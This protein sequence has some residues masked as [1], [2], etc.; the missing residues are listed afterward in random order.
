MK[1]D[2]LINCE[3]YFGMPVDLIPWSYVWR[4]DRTVQEHPEADLIVRRLRR[5]DTIYR[6]ALPEMG[7]ELTKSIHYKQDAMLTPLLPVPRDPLLTGALWVGGITDYCVTLVWQ[8]GADIPD[9][10]DVEVRT[11]PCAWGWFGFTVDRVLE[12]PVIS[13]DGRRWTYTPPSDWMM[14]FAYSRQV[15]AASE[16]IAVFAPEG[17]AIPTLQITGDSLGV[18]EPLDLCVEW[19]HGYTAEQVEAR[20]RTHVAHVITYE[21]DMAAC[22]AHIRCLYSKTGRFGNDSK[23][24]FILNEAEGEGATVLL[25]ELAEQ[26][27]W[28]KEQ[29]LLF[30]ADTPGFDADAY[31]KRAQVQASENIRAR[32]RAHREPESFE[33]TF[34]NVR[35]WR[36][37]KGSKLSEFPAAP[38]GQFELHVPDKQWQAMYEHA[39]EQLRG[40]HMWGMLSS[41]VARVTLAMELNGLH[42]YTQKIYDYFLPSPGIK[43]DGDFTDPSGSL[44]WARAMR[45][46]MGY[47]HEGTH[48]STGKLLF[49]MAYRYFMT[50]DA[51]WMRALLPRLKQAADFIIRE[52]NGYLSDIPNRDQLHVAGLMPPIMLGDYALPACDWRWYYTDNAYALLGLEAMAKAMEQLGDADAAHYR[53][54]AEAFRQDLLRVLKREVLSAPVRC[55]ADGV[56]RSFIP[57]IAYGG[58]LLHY[59]EETNI[60]QYNF[61]IN[62]LFD[63]ALA[64]C[65][66][67]G[68]LP[69]T[70]RRAIGTVDGMEV[71]GMKISVASLAA[72]DHPAA[73][74][75]ARR[76]NERLANRG[77]ARATPVDGAADEGHDLW[78]WNTFADLPKISHNANLYLLQDDIPGFLRFFFNHAA[79]MVG[80]N[81]KL[82][83]H[84]HPSVIES[85]E[86]PDNGTAGWFVENFRNML[87]TEEG[88]TLWITKGTPRAWL[89]DGCEIRIGGAPTVF[90]SLD[91]TVSSAVDADKITVTLQVPVRRTPGEI[92]IRLRH[93]AAKRIAHV[94]TD[95]QTR[96]VAIAPDG[97]TVVLTAPHGGEQ[98]CVVV[99]Y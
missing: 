52:R 3:A 19:G 93:P 84:A 75:A 69:A 29:G 45:H 39:I 32:I 2:R 80:S 40:P 31:I 54:E 57:H 91:Y 97:E 10:A 21:A 53:A 50:G 64:L 49:S 1:N 51:A 65:D 74:E 76:E 43:S 30:Y 60:P 23:L 79:V 33:E 77:V 62:N 4:R 87:L 89:R 55:G 12:H 26:P 48:S 81:G 63:G 92:R 7:P 25:R 78:F 68:V 34:N 17:A 56:S 83:E 28:V 35:L 67:D 8:E 86:N 11:Y 61:G 22:R 18:W 85:C 15:R 41:E 70:D 73:S 47:N 38:K 42:E 9:P 88:D 71:G 82:W 90:G 6:T 37:P 46:D 14:D 59:G 27:I 13:E 98:V 44:E 72:L 95:S 36:C 16:M 66:R 5:M 94:T 20:V 58:G 24:T 99:R 96:K